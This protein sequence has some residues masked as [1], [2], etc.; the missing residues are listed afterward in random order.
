MALQIFQQV[1]RIFAA[2]LH[3]GEGQHG[4]HHVVSGLSVQWVTGF[5]VDHA[6]QG[7]AADFVLRIDLVAQQHRFG[8]GYK[9]V[10]GC[11]VDDLLPIF[12]GSDQ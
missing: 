8:A 9:L 7:H 2:G 6:E 10:M 5:G 1:G 11:L 12:A 4:G 3:V